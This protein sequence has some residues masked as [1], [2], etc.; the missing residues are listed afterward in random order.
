MNCNR[1]K[2]SDDGC[3]NVFYCYIFLGIANAHYICFLCRSAHTYTWNSIKTNSTCFLLKNCS[4]SNV[5]KG[6]SKGLLQYQKIKG[7]I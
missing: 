3:K 6:T 5:Y 7:S 4:T 1:I 2:N